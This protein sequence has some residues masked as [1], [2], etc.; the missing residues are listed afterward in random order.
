MRTHLPLCML[1]A[2]ASLAA[3]DTF[4]LPASAATGSTNGTEATAPFLAPIRMGQHRLVDRNTLNGQGLPA[5]FSLWD[6][7][8][9]DPTGRY[10]FTPSENPS[11][12]GIFRYDTVSHQMVV[13]MA[14]NTAL[15][16]SGNPVGW[17]AGNDNFGRFD[18][19]TFTP[20]GTI[21][22]GE[23]TTGG[24]L[25]E[26]T[27]P[28]S[29]GPFNV[30]WLTS[31]PSMNHEG[32]RF[33]AAGNLYTVDEDNSGCVYKFVPGTP[34]DLSAPGQSFVL[35]VDAY[36]ADPNA[37]PN[38]NWNSTTNRLTT[39]VGAAH[40]EPLTGR[41]GQQITTQN[42]FVYATVNAGRLAA[43]EVFGTPFG[44]PED[45]DL[46][47]LANGNQCIYF[48]ATSENT[49]YSIELTGASTAIV[50]HFVDYDTINLATGTDVNPLQ[51]DPYTSAGPGTVFDA[52]DNISSDA[53]GNIYIVEDGEPNGGDIWKATD[54]NRD[55]VA[56]AIG[57]F[58]SLG[59]TGSEPTGMIWHPTDPYRFLVNVQHPA[60]GNDATWVFDTRPYA[61][62]NQDLELLTGVNKAPTAAPGEFVR[63][64]AGFDTVVV[65]VRSPAASLD[66]QPFA[67]LVQ[68]FFTA[69]GMAPFLPPL[70]MN[71]FLATFPLV[72]GY[73]GQFPTVLPYGGSSTAV[74][75][76]PGLAGL[77]IMVQGL[78]V[79]PTGELVLTDGHEVVLQ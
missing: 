61:G 4:P 58:V 12:A 75:V 40:W 53:F 10:V 78:A 41:N 64:A 49:I 43:D 25:F 71:P 42:P 79:A 67:V 52:P 9:F 63:T 32:M 66:A 46:N 38:Q 21:I 31:I 39:R 8:A 7:S 3:Q 55:G 77:S 19:C 5:S 68:P 15:P 28:L 72:G 16:R 47:R 23:E 54:A 34:G 44:R 50:R 76:P 73:V 65:G 1:A 14:G 20:N 11:G 69:S 37:A 30:R 6:M 36:A 33:D 51:N 17:S 35:S 62:S 74:L 26:V 45:M 48:A 29:N 22:T 60:S 56:E 57:I 70:W 27:N 13:L 2:A 18:P 59:I 24:R